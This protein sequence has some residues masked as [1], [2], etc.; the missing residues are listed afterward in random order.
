MTFYCGQHQCCECGEKT[1]NA[2]GLILRCRWCHRGYCDD[3]LDWERTEL[4][5]ETLP[6][7]E[8]LGFG[9]VSQA[10]YIGCPGCSKQQRDHPEVA[11]FCARMSAQFDRQLL[12]AKSVTQAEGISIPPAERS[13]RTAS[14][15]EATTADGSGPATPIMAPENHQSPGKGEQAF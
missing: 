14:M 2:G 6:E 3:C 8:T 5:S 13:S 10:Y 4:I 9:D 12:E 11:A 15:T 7:F 1:Q